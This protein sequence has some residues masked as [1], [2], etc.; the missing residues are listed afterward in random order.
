MEVEVGNGGNGEEEVPNWGTSLPVESVQEIVRK[1]PFNVP[2]KY[3]HDLDC[4]QNDVVLP[5]LSSDIPVID[6]SLLSVGDEVELQKLDM[7]CSDWGFFQIINHGIEGQ[8]LQEVKDIAAKF[9]ELPIEEKKKYSMASNDVQGYGQVYVVSEEQKLDWA[10]L[11]ILVVYPTKFRKSIFWPTS[12]PEF[13]KAIEEYSSEANRVAKELFSSLS[14]LLGMEKD[15]LLKLHDEVMQAMRINFYPTC[16]MP[17]KVVGVSP[18]SDTSTLTVLLQDDEVTGLQIRHSGGWI[19]VKPIPNALVVNVGDVIE[20]L[21][22][23]KYKSIEHRAMTNESKVRMSIASF[24]CPQDDVQIEPLDTMVDGA[25]NMPR[26]KRMRYGDY[27]RYSLKTKMD[28]KSHTNLIKL[29]DE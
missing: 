3:I 13:I 28:G 21:S 19:P 17:D 5:Q 23:G 18:H 10:D 14:I 16:S 27:L 24:I 25:E 12:P 4:I 15:S 2:E 8:I 22:N 29:E 1:D 20:V 11:F 26:Y 7:A 9:F 6:L